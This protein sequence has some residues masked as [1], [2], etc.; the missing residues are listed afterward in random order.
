MPEGDTLARTAE[1][2]RP[3]LVGRT[4]TAARTGGPGAQ[5]QV[6]RVVGA[7]IDSVDSLGKNL[8]IRFDNG[9]ELRTHLRMNGAWHRYRPGERWRRPPARARL[10][11]EVPGAVAVC[12]DA[13]TVELFEQR[14]EAV[15]PSLSALGPDVLSPDFDPA[16]AV[17]RLRDPSR[18]RRA[19]A[20]ALTDQRALAGIGN[21]YK[22]EVLFIERVS[23]FTPVR[24]ID[25]E[26][27]GRLVG[28]ARRLMVANASRSRGPERITSDGTGAG[29]GAA[30]PQWVYRRTGRPCRRCG[31]PIASRRQ[32]TDLA[33]MTYWCPRCQGGA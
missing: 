33:R 18:A 29:A 21:V 25:D 8:L 13:P 26:T 24:E 20:E 22:N 31:T 19:I 32:G 6:S 12:F 2:L 4:V 10:V 27:L 17:S 7:R 5:A 9:L 30:G 28:T 14:A 15:H 11:L 16:V 1:G 23:P 3:H